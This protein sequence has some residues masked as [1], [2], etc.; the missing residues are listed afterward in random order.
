M[1]VE[2]ICTGE[3]NSLEKVSALAATDKWLAIGGFGKDEKG[4]VEVW[5]A[6]G[7]GSFAAIVAQTGQMSISSM[8]YVKECLWLEAYLRITFLK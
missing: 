3:V 8:F 1:S 5:S 4:L 6:S 2:T 7:V